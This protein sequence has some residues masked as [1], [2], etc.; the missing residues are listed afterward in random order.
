MINMWYWCVLGSSAT[1]RGDRWDFRY[2]ILQ[3]GCI[4]DQNVTSVCGWSGKLLSR[5]HFSLQYW[6]ISKTEIV[7]LIKKRNQ[8]KSNFFLTEISEVRKC[9]KKIFVVFANNPL[10]PWQ[11]LW[12]QF[13]EF[14]IGSTNNPLIDILLYSHHFY[15]WY[16]IDIVRR[17]SVLITDGSERVKY[18]EVVLQDLSAFCCLK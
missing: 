14:G 15:A 4:S 12:C 10:T 7:R 8:S 18:C 1:S 3:Q 6:Y 17:N 5:F 2:N 9:R 13:G 16:C 11:F